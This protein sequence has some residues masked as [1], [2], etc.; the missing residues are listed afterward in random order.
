MY[1]LSEPNWLGLLVWPPEAW[2]VLRSVGVRVMGVC[3]CRKYLSDVHAT[4]AYVC[5]YLG[6]RLY[7]CLI[8]QQER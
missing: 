8:L 7:T 6:F 4:L 5:R 1:T 2:L 3:V